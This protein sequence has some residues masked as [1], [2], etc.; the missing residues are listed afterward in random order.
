[1]P[2]TK[3]TDKVDLDRLARMFKLPE[4]DSVLEANI[5]YVDENVRTAEREA[6]ED[7]TEAELEKIR[8][9]AEIEAQDE[10][11]SQYH[12]AVMSAAEQLF[13]EHHLELV[14]VKKGERYPFEFRIEPV[15]GKT[16]KDAAK[17]LATTING[18]G[19]TYE[20]P[21]E[22]GRA[23]RQYVLSRLSWVSSYPEVYGSSSASRIYERSWR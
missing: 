8:E 9:E 2:E 13:G 7:A 4:W 10:V 5:D 12:G 14:P 1:M 19:L 20:D 18:V 11:Y 3:A 22:Y 15:S 17:Q 16:W 6:D 23:P 21:S